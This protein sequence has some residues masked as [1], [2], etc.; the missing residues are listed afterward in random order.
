M[1]TVFQIIILLLF[2]VLLLSSLNIS[3]AVPDDSVNYLMDKGREETGAANIVTS[4]YLG[5]RAFDTLGETIVLLVSVS[6]VVF[7]IGSRK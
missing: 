4:I 7:L 5:Y 1:K 2:S 6:G 3:Q